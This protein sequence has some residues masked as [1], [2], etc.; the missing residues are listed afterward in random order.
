M[1]YKS[2]RLTVPLEVVEDGLEELGQGARATIATGIRELE[3]KR[4]PARDVEIF[5]QSVAWQSPTLKS[6]FANVQHISK[7]DE[8]MQFQVLSEEDMLELCC[9]NWS[10]MAGP[11]ATGNHQCC[12]TAWVVDDFD[13]L[14]PLNQPQ[15]FSAVSNHNW[16]GC[17]KHVRSL[18]N[19]DH[20]ALSEADNTTDADDIPDIEE[21]FEPRGISGRGGST[22]SLCLDNSVVSPCCCSDF[23]EEVEVLESTVSSP[24][25]DS[26][27]AAG[28]HA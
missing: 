27:A 20:L 14:A 15:G 1:V 10:P 13:L 8:D 28:L 9:D 21:A 19:F 16:S 17:L 3:A 18:N 2:Y 22:L 5:L 26:D 12:R 25:A 24:L 7:E 6:Y 4:M 23:D 11:P